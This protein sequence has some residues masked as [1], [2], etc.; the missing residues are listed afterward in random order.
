MLFTSYGFIAF[1]CVLFVA[2]Y[3]LPKKS[4][5][6]ILLAASYIFYAFAG[7]DCLVFI[8]VTT[9]SAYFVA[10]LMGRLTRKEGIYLEENRD[11]LDKESRKKYKAAVK[12][13][14]FYILLCG[15]VLNFGILAVIKYSAF[16]VSNVNTVIGLFGKKGF[17]LPDL[18]LP[19]GISFYIFQ[20][21]GYLIDVYRQ[22]TEV[23]KNPFKLALFVS[24]FPQ[25]VQGPIS[26]HS[27]LAPQ[28][29][30][31]HRFELRGFTYGLQRILWGYFKKLV[32]ADRALVAMKAL[33][34]TP[35]D[36]EPEQFA[37]AYVLLLILIYSVQIYA[38]FTGG[39]D[40]T[41]GIAE[42][43]G[44]KLKENFVRPFSSRST[45]EYW[46]RWHITMGTWFTDYIF[47]PVSVCKPMMKLSK[48]SR[49]VLGNN[50]G[51]RIPVYLAT[52][53]TWFLTGLWHGAGWNFIVWGLLNCAVILVSQEL[54]PVYSR[55][56]ER[57]PRLTG[58]TAYG[59]F[60]AVRTFLLMGLIRSLDC[61][62]DVGRTFS[63]WGSMFTEWNIGEVLSGIGS[64]FVSASN[65]FLGLRLADYIV[66]AV[67]IG[68]MSVVSSMSAKKSVRERIYDKP[69]LSWLLCGCLLFMIV[70]FGAYSIG[71]DASQFIYNQF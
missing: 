26:R 6:G 9:V 58:C 59:K 36:G 2:Y 69:A 11:S 53:L 50:I 14:R 49:K 10:R 1:L 46:N 63:L 67:G 22:K 62:R 47:Y 45:K 60:M 7:L 31:E 34:K 54:E 23:E 5:W 56:R 38:D 27:D 15:L 65:K 19:M 4:Q 44:I 43:L 70:M 42:A 33:L 37:G 24:F 48:W 68:V 71:Y 61:Y 35:G 66:I 13:R 64:L 32:I 21:M 16:A 57:F 30:A 28:L 52:I 3:L 18:L 41:I 55:F 40:I 29:Y 51:K 8:L 39:I 25:L 17:D 20:T 12:K